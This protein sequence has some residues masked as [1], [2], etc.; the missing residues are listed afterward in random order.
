MLRCLAGSPMVIFGMADG[1]A[2]SDSSAT[3]QPAF[4][5][6][7]C[8]ALRF[9]H[10]LNLGAEKEIEIQLLANSTNVSHRLNR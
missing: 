6:L 7:V 5:R 9:G 2:T 3:Q 8:L 10:T 4:S 1:L